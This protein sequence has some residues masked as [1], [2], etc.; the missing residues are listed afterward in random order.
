MSEEA[1]FGRM[2]ENE[3]P[4]GLLGKA[5]PVC[6]YKYGTEWKKEEVP[7]DIIEWLFNLPTTKVKP[8]WI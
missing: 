7:Q 5:C 6:G 8:A 2:S 3:H 1:L 4:D